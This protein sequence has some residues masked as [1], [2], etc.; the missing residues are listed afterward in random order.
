MKMGHLQS[1]VTHIHRV[2][3]MNSEEDKE[4]EEGEATGIKDN[5]GKL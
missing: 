5:I 2:Y 4:E 1:S 3:C